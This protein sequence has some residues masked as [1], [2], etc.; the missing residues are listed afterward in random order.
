[1]YSDEMVDFIDRIDGQI[2]GKKR[3]REFEMGIGDLNAETKRQGL[4]GK[5]LGGIWKGFI[6]FTSD[7][8]SGPEK[9]I[10]MGF[11][12]QEKLFREQD[13]IQEYENQ[14]LYGTRFAFWDKPWRDWFRP[15]AYQTAHGIL[16]WQGKPGWVED[17][18][19]FEQ[20]YDQLEFYKWKRLEAQAFDSGDAYKAKQYGRFAS[21]TMTGVNPL[22]RASSVKG[23]LPRRE[24][25]FFE[26]FVMED[27]ERRRERILQMVH[28][29]LM[30][31]YEAQWLKADYARTGDP[32]LKRRLQLLGRDQGVQSAGLVASGEAEQVARGREN[33]NFADWYKMRNI[34]EQ[35]GQNMP[36]TD[37]IGFNPAVDLEDVKLKVLMDQGQDI[38]DYGFFRSQRRLLSR[39]P[40][41]NPD[42]VSQGSPYTANDRNL[43]STIWDSNKIDIT[44]SRGYG[45]RTGGGVTNTVDITYYD[46]RNRE[47]AIYKK[48]FGL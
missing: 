46:N 7:L 40:Y 10:P 26:A 5:A 32:E 38:H 23:A 33:I 15:A 25:E 22:G 2:E 34:E 36:D 8:A 30:P 31:V 14:V 18:E 17:R 24:R 19:K 42:T 11:R 27:D 9:L 48:T 37:W 6:R 1:M 12:P 39:K 16:G 4:V 43:S 44:Q 20:H 29:A 41:I 21:R 45:Y 35:M 47:T 28:P 13:A 3:R